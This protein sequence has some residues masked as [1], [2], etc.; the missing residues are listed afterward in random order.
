MSISS[1]VERGQ[2]SAYPLSQEARGA[3]IVRPD[4]RDIGPQA[5]P[6]LNPTCPLGLHIACNPRGFLSKSRISVHASHV[7]KGSAWRNVAGRHVRHELPFLWTKQKADFS[8]VLQSLGTVVD[9]SA[10]R[11]VAFVFFN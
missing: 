6:R 8:D 9:R 2:W 11:D 1:T 3:L 4:T 5:R 10:D 7:V